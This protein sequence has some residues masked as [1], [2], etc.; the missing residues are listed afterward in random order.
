MR[1]LLLSLDIFIKQF[2][3]FINDVSL[4]SSDIAHEKIDVNMNVMT[5][6]FFP[7]TLIL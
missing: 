3:L 5:S 2:S 4:I 6:I 7:P 1:T